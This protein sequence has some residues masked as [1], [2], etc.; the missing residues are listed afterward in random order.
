MIQKN[1]RWMAAV[2]L[3]PSERD[4]TLMESGRGCEQHR[5]DYAGRRGPVTSR[6]GVAARDR[7]VMQPGGLIARITCDTVAATQAEP[8]EE[9]HWRTM[10][11]ETSTRSTKRDSGTS[12]ARSTR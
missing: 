5:R 8:G 9:G 11:Q 7:T 2:L 6:I 1:L 4:R 3:G 10:P 12:S